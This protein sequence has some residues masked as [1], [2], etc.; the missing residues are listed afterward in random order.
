MRQ[1]LPHEALQP[2]I[3]ELTQQVDQAIGE[4]T[5]QGL[6]DAKSTYDGAPFASRL[7]LASAACTRPELAVGELF[8][9]GEADFGRHVYLAHDAG[10]AG[11]DRGIDRA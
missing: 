5:R 2:L 10:A 6:L 11:R 3:D 8:F 4:A 9:T 1:M 7:A